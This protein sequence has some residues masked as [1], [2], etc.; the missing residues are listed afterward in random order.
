MTYII[1]TKTQS[2]V[3]NQTAKKAGKCRGAQGYWVSS[4]MLYQGDSLKGMHNDKNYL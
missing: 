2:Q 4:T 1:T 3:F